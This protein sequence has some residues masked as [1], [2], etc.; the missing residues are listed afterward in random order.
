MEWVMK[1]LKV[2]MKGKGKGDEM[3]NAVLTMTTAALWDGTCGHLS[4]E[5]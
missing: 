4:R 2:N 1:L 5:G 3:N